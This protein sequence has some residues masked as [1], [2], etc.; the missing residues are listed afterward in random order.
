LTDY[1]EQVDAVR[2]EQGLDRKD[3]EGF[4]YQ[5]YADR[6]GLN[7]QTAAREVERLVAA[8]RLLKGKARRT[9]NGQRRHVNVFRPAPK[10]QESAT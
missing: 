3:D 9:V 7:Y 6:Y 5:E 8:G 4:T 2:K 10:I 1:L